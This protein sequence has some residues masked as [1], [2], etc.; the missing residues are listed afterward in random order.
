M[1]L[2][3]DMMLLIW[4]PRNFSIYRNK[5]YFDNGVKEAVERVRTSPQQLK[6]QGYGVDDLPDEINVIIAERSPSRFFGTY[7]KLPNR[8]NAYLA[9][10]TDGR[11]SDKDRD[12]EDYLLTPDGLRTVR[13][14]VNPDMPS[15]EAVESELRMALSWHDEIAA[16]PDMDPSWSYQ[17]EFGMDPP[18][19]Y[20]VRPFRPLVKAGFTVEEPDD[21]RGLPVVIGVT[22]P[23]GIDL[24]VVNFPYNS[25]KYMDEIDI[26]EGEPLLFSGD[27]TL[28]WRIEDRSDV[29]A[30][31]LS[32]RQG[33][34]SHTDVKVLRKLQVAALFNHN[35]YRFGEGERVR[36]FSDGVNIKVQ[37]EE[38]K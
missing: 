17:I 20:Q 13:G 24:Q 36:L 37:G 30:A 7:I 10:L 22:P 31:I 2:K 26:P 12:R 32:H 28:A 4:N 29:K 16:L 23:E 6:E 14:R 11:S 1:I 21:Y 5:E 18:C 27:L 15:L 19:L 34:L 35:P 38:Q 3:P 9:S 8:D 25:T 33:L